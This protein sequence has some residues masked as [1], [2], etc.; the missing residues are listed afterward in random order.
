[1]T[2]NLSSFHVAK[3]I[4]LKILDK[5]AKSAGPRKGPLKFRYKEC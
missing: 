2:G 5:S 4:F 1:M 3:V